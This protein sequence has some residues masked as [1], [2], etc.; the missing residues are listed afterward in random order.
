MVLPV[1]STRVKVTRSPLFSTLPPPAASTPRAWSSWMTA[2][3]TP[4]R[5]GTRVDAEARGPCRCP[6]LSRSNVESSLAYGPH[7]AG[8]QTAAGSV[9]LMTGNP[10]RRRSR[11]GHV[12]PETTPT[13][14]RTV[15]CVVL[16]VIGQVKRRRFDWPGEI[17]T[18]VQ[19][20]CTRPT[21]VLHPPLSGNLHI[22]AEGFPEFS[23]P[24]ACCSRRSEIRF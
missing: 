6:V 16:W 24:P 5:A 15:R 1:T 13:E 8:V 3:V 22:P 17:C 19:P 11:A 23:P 4:H 2:S 9:A 7:A 14:P 18:L 20:G 10:A 12:L 21:D